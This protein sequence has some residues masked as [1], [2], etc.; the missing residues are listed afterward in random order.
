[1]SRAS[2][3]HIRPRRCLFRALCVRPTSHLFRGVGFLTHPPHDPSILILSYSFRSSPHVTRPNFASLPASLLAQPQGIL[4]FSI[5]EPTVGNCD[6]LDSGCDDDFSDL[7]ELDYCS[8][9]TGATDRGFK[10]YNCTFWDNL[11]SKQVTQSSVMLTTRVTETTQTNK[12]EAIGQLPSNTCKNLWSNSAVDTRFIA[13]AEKFTILLDHSVQT[14]TTGIKGSSRSMQGK[15]RVD[16]SPKK[17]DPS[18]EWR[19]RACAMSRT[20][21]T[22]PSSGKATKVAPCF[23]QPFHPNGTGLDTFTLETLTG[24][25]GLDLDSKSIGNGHSNRYNG[26]VVIVTITYDNTHKFKGVVGNGTGSNIFYTYSISYLE[27]ATFKTV[28]AIYNPFPNKRVVLNR[29]G[30]RIFVVQAGQL[31]QF[32]VTQLLPQLT[33]SLTLLAIASSVVDFFMMYIAP[34][35]ETYKQYKYQKTVD[36]SDF[37]LNQQK[38][39]AADLDGMNGDL[40]KGHNAHLNDVLRTQ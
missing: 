33:T 21:A 38:D 37:R 13:D 40:A 5:Q 28:D 24:A 4:R 14:P 12:C 7:S 32:D 20:G 8:Q 31:G 1:M 18:N 27:D 9:Y 15:L 26:A 17:D 36:M 2:H 10:R 11:Q 30:I 25:G 34:Q 23:I 3:T 19:D 22:N 39:R 35:R 16:R 29:H 6:P